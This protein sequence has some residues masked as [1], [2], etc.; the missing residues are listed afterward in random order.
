[1]SE[2]NE[3]NCPLLFTGDDGGEEGWLIGNREGLIALR[4]AIDASLASGEA[5][6][7]EAG[8]E[9]VGIRCRE[10]AV[11]PDREKEGSKSA[12]VGCL[13]L[14]IACFLI[15][16]HGIIDLLGKLF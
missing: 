1:M 15:F 11:G 9:F 5:A 7:S 2:E 13:I 8:I 3:E 6:I 4:T 10:E 16:L 14:I 12:K